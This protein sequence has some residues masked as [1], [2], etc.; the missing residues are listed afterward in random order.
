MGLEDVSK[1]ERFSYCFGS[2][3]EDEDCCEKPEYLVRSQIGGWE[4]NHWEHITIPKKY[5]MWAGPWFRALC[6]KHLIER[7]LR[8]E[9]MIAKK[10]YYE[11]VEDGPGCKESRDEFKAWMKHRAEKAKKTIEDNLANIEEHC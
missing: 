11:M 1:S 10:D 7:Y 3:K 8:I 9:D 4:H 6:R 2:G 5:R